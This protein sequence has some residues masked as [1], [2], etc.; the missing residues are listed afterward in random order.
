ML[1]AITTD[2]VLVLLLH[3]ALRL[4]VLYWLMVTVMITTPLLILPQLKF[5]T[6]LMMIATV[7]TDEGVF[8]NYY[9]DA[10]N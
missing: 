3:L 7:V 9:A 4:P 2:S 8:L 10:D 6:L 1:M 5:V